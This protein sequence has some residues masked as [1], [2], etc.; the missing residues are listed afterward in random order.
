VMIVSEKLTE[1]AKD[2]RP[3]PDNYF[4]LVNKDLEVELRK[5]AV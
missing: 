4:V 3:V 2:W 5:V 1:Y